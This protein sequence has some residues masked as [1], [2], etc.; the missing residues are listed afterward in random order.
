MIRR[1]QFLATCLMYVLIASYSC[2]AA[3]SNNVLMIEFLTSITA[4]D[5]PLGTWD[6][7]VKGT[8]E[9]Y[10]KGVLFVRLE[11]GQH[12]VEVHLGNGVLNGDDVKI[13]GNTLKFIVNL[14]GV[15]RVTVVLN[16]NEDTIVGEAS[17]SQGSFNITG[18]RKLPPQ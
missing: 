14:D 6:Y 16:A 10:R 1:F 8:E 2:Y 5:G 3:P 4:N 7:E 18:S 12:F 9:A 15:Q 13:E 17:S 11:N